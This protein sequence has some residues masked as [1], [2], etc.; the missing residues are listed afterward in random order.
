MPENP[1]EGMLSERERKQLLAGLHTRLF[2]V[3][4]EVPYSV[5]IKGKKCRLHDQVWILLNKDELSD[6]D[7]EHIHTYISYLREKEREDELELNTKNLTRKEAK[8][9]FNETAGLLR[10]IMD[11]REIEDGTAKE[12]EKEFEDIFSRERIIEARRWLQ[13]LKD[14]EMLQ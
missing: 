14:R 5:D 6:D 13:F 8:N 10:A 11:L 4:E 12:K 3:G 1:K 9:L 7:I 2:W